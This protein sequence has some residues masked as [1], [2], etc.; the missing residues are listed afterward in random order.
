MSPPLPSKNY[1]ISSAFS[2]NFIL[3][4]TALNYQE[5]MDRMNAEVA[6]EIA[7]C[8]LKLKAEQD[9]LRYYV[10]LLE[11]REAEVIRMTY[12]DGVDQ[13]RVAESLGVVPRTMRR[14]KKEAI[15]KLAEMY[16]FTENPMK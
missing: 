8:L 5:Q 14:I 13:N 16:A 6:N 10:S 15:I 11:N 7:E 3:A 12:F 2:Y 1:K 4:L 9:Q